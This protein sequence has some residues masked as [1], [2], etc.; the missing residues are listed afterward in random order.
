MT[1]LDIIYESAHAQAHNKG[2]VKFKGDYQAW[3]QEKRRLR[4]KDRM[5]LKHVS[6]SELSQ[7][8]D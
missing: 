8:S 5:S 2:I 4:R 3:K 6:T 1:C 7:S